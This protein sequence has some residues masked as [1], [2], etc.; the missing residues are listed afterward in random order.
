MWKIITHLAGKK[1]TNMTRTRKTTK[2]P[3]A[4]RRAVKAG[5]ARKSA[6]AKTRAGQRQA[7]ARGRRKKVVS[8]RKSAAGR[9]S[10]LNQTAY[11][12]SDELQ[13]V[14]GAKRLTRPQI[15]KKLWNYIKANKC[16]DSNNR[17]MIIPDNKLAEVIGKK[18]VDMLK[19]ASLLNKHIQ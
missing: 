18:P 9:K 14:V 15:V 17:R 3:A 11:S 1:E 19:L 7:A 12:V 5:A 8:S 10:A 6:A 16:Q 2:R 4:G 13:A